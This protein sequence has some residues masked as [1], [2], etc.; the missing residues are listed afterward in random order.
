MSAMITF[1][2]QHIPFS[3]FGSFLTVSHLPQNGKRE[4]GLYLRTVRGGDET[5]GAVF[6]LELVAG[7]EVVPYSVHSAPSSL[8]LIG[9]GG[10]GKAELCLSE[11]EAMR[12]RVREA[13]IRLTLVAG[14][15][16]YVLPRQDGRYEVNH[17][18]TEMRF[19]LTSL[20]GKLTVDD[21]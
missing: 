12:I 2:I 6:R 5:S 8:T 18:T 4:E 1:D 10:Q 19:M 20:Q 11:P 21:E 3:R 13:G 15:Y 7:G 9:E 17:F 14:T 16:D